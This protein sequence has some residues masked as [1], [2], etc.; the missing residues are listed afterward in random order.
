VKRVDFEVA[1]SGRGI[2]AD[3]LDAIFDPFV[4]LSRTPFEP[5]EG[6]GLGLAISRRLAA[7]MDG[8]LTVT[9]EVGVGSTFRLSLR[10]AV[11]EEGRPTLQRA[12]QAAG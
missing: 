4:Q 8:E 5:R 1:D 7:D 3:K 9:S 11:E 2:P 12:T 10:A 6:V